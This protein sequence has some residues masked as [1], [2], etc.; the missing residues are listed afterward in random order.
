MRPAELVK[1]KASDAAIRRLARK[2]G[3]L[4]RLLRVVM[5][6]MRGCPPLD[7]ESDIAAGKAFYE[8]RMKALEI[9]Q[10][11]PKPVILGSHLIEL[12]YEPSPVFRSVLD[13]CFEAQLD[14]VFTDE[15][16]GI[17]YLKEYIT[18][19]KPNLSKID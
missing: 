17:A 18:G 5:A 15:K 13:D 6:D 11:A 14:G 10:N 3:R 19:K 1:A 9:E 2:V 4:D 12:G 7:H 16:E 8:E